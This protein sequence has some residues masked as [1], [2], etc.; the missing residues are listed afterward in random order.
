MDHL[1]PVDRHAEEADVAACNLADALA[2]A[3]WTPGAAEDATHAIETL[4]TALAGLGPEAAAILA[5][6]L[7]ATTALTA[8]LADD[9]AP[10]GVQEPVA[11]PVGRQQQR[12]GLGPRGRLLRAVGDDTEA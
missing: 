1:P 10:G 3:P 11:L 7:S 5:P 2:T 8:H 4:T 6:V 9:P 12:R